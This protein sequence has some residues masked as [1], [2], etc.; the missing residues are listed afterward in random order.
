[1]PSYRVN[2]G[3]GQGHE[4]GGRRLEPRGGAHAGVQTQSACAGRA[5]P[6]WQSQAGCWRGSMQT[7]PP[8]GHPALRQAPVHPSQ[9]HSPHPSTGGGCSPDLGGLPY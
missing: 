2:G 8:R 6:S 5:A 4:S 9:K 7:S 3:V 1:M